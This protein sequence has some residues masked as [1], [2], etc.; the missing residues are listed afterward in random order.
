MV[1]TALSF[2]MN[3]FPYSWIRGL[4]SGNFQY[5]KKNF[6]K[7]QISAEYLISNYSIANLIITLMIG[8]G[9]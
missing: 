4:A 1:I 9:I 7:N 6:V 8:E 5:Y 2:F 3:N